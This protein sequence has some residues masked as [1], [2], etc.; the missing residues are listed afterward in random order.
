[1]AMPENALQA[2]EEGRE[3]FRN[4]EDFNDSPYIDPSHPWAMLWQLG[5]AR[6]MWNSI[7]HELQLK[8]RGMGD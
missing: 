6:E 8:L 1:M 7:P 4:G 5:W 3:A 2:L